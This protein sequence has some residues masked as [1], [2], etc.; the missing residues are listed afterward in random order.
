MLL[1]FSVLYGRTG[2]ALDATDAGAWLRVSP[3]ETLLLAC[4]AVL[5][6]SDLS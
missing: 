6:E 5:L 4:M 2:V 1:A 3:L